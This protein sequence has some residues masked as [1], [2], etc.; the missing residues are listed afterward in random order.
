MAETLRKLSNVPP[1]HRA[2]W[3]RLVPAATL[4]LFLGPIGAGLAFTLLPAFGWLPALGGTA[5][6]LAP[7]RELLAAPEFP[8]ALRLTLFSGLAS[9]V[10]RSEEHTSELQSLMRISYAVFCLK[11]KKLMIKQHTL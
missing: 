3:L 4:A 2:G 7:W 5:F 8:G 11:K 9:T 1:S 10:I 6:G